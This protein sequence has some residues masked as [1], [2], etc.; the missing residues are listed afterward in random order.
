MTFRDLR[1][2]ARQVERDDDIEVAWERLAQLNHRAP[3]CCAGTSLLH[4]YP[5]GPSA[6][7]PGSPPAPAKGTVPSP[8]ANP[9]AS[10]TQ[11]RSGTLR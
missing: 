10:M 8:P 1:E 3:A 2:L 9:P 5:R 6:E 11:G 7:R 4:R